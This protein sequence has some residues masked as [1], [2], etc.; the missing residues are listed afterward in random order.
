[1]ATETTT[2]PITTQ[3][4]PTTVPQQTQVPNTQGTD[5]TI[6]PTLTPDVVPA[7]PT[8]QTQVVPNQP[9]GMGEY[10]NSIQQ[11]ALNE[12]QQADDLIDG[13]SETMDQVN[14]VYAGEQTTKIAPPTIPTFQKAPEAPKM[15][16]LFNSLRGNYGLTQLEN[17]LNELK[18]EQEAVYAR[19]RQRT[20]NERGKQVTMGVIGGRTNEIQQ[21]EQENLDFINRQINTKVGQINTANSL[22]NT[23]MTLTG[24]DWDN[25]VKSY[26]MNLETTFKVYDMINSAVKDANAVVDQNKEFARA[27]MQVYMDLISNGQMKYENLSPVQ[28]AEISKLEAQAGFPT[29][30]I[31]SVKPPPGYNL[32]SVTKRVDAKT[33]MAYADMI[34]IGDDGKPYTVTQKLGKE[35]LSAQEQLDMAKKQ[36]Q[37]SASSQIAVQNNAARIANEKAKKDQQ[38]Q[39]SVMARALQSQSGSDGYVHPDTFKKALRDWQNA[40]L[41]TSTFFENMGVYVN[42]NHWWEYGI[43]DKYVP[44]AKPRG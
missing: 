44:N 28:K 43:S 2:A 1:M 24:Q 38:N 39:L 11:T 18:T 33:G 5:T 25:A 23:M 4:V 34:Y 35:G 12:T 31:S 26:E 14:K 17:G 29:G 15:V 32:K 3:E 6:N 40:N 8:Y 9:E 37:I 22:I 21:Q 7:T 36:A 19:L 41:P 42:P 13:A 16:D 30:F 27:N 10:L 20:L